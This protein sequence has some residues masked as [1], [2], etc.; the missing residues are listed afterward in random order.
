MSEASDHTTSSLI[1]S[2]KQET[3]INKMNAEFIYQPISG[4]Y[5]E[6]H[7]GKVTPNSLWVKFT[8][9][10]EQEWVGSFEQSWIEEAKFIIILKRTEKV[11]VVASGQSF[12][13]DINS[14]EQ[15]NKLEISDTKTAL[16]NEQDEFIYYSSGF[17]LRYTDNQGND[18]ILFDKYY[19]DDVKLVEIKDNKLYATYWNYQTSSNPFH[20]EIDLLTK[21][22]KD[23]FYNEESKTYS[24]E[25]SNPNLLNKLT[26]LITK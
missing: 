17:D 18:E 15:L 10:D 1:L 9:K 6:K 22:V 19:F 14:C 8:T 16:L 4:T 26:K 12:L 3:I 7:F 20:F 13:I 21:E 23:S 2:A 24:K 5:P 25:N 11:F